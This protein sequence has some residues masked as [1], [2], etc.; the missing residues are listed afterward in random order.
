MVEDFVLKYYN[1]LII[2]VAKKVK[3]F[4]KEMRN[5]YKVHYNS[6]ILALHD[7]N[8]VTSISNKQYCIGYHNK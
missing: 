3:A 2:F 5:Y 4:Y 1:M 7:R 8:A 6:I